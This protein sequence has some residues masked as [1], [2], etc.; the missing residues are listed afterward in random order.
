MA[1]LTNPS[2]RS[3]RVQPATEDSW[4]PSRPDAI[5]LADDEVHVWRSSLDVTTD[6]LARLSGV[7]AINEIDRAARFRFERHRRRWVAARA[8][9]RHLL[10]GYLG[11]SATAIELSV[12][13]RGK[14]QVL[15]SSGDRPALEFNLS[16]SGDLALFAFTRSRRV[17]A[18]VEIIK[19][20]AEARA[21]ALHTLTAR[22]LAPLEDLEGE[23]LARAFLRCWTR[24]EAWLKATGE[25]LGGRLTSLE[26]LPA[27]TPETTR[28]SPRHTMADR[29]FLRDLEPRP[30]AVGCLAIEGPPIAVVLLALETATA[31]ST[32]SGGELP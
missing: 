26:V 4:R 21:L 14:P 6:D 9:L 7:L 25:G 20:L 17:G 11:R 24:K 30:K 19:P 28:P 22:E 15:T 3:V 27:A 16:H 2:I 32:L 10:G 18:D 13:A 23:L 5:R 12:G 29:W 8:Q 1:P 31:G